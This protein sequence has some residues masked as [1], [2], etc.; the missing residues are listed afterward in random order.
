MPALVP[1]PAAPWELYHG[2][3]DSRLDEITRNGLP[4]PFVTNDRELAR[5][6]A[7]EAAA[8]LGGEPVVLVIRGCDPALLEVDLPALEE[9][10]FVGR[11][12]RR[13]K[14]LAKERGKSPEEVVWEAA[15]LA[16]TEQGLGSWC[17]LSGLAS[18]SLTSS[19][20]CRAQVSSELIAER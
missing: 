17:E 1:T 18:L 12:G 9:P 6:Y 14:E 2:T 13:W 10:V 8:G 3:S 7:Q 16:C 19:A 4:E 20:R 11:V 5:Y 15:D